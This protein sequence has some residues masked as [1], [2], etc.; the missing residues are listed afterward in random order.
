MWRSLRTQLGLIFLAF[1]M[2]VTGS[3]TATFWLVKTQHDDAT[4]INLAGRQRM[5]TQQMTRLALTQPDSPDLA[6][7]SQRFEQTLYALRNGGKALDANG[8]LVTLPTTTNPAIRS[9]LDEAAH[10]WAAFSQYLG[11]SDDDLLLIESDH[12]LNQLDQ[13][14]SA[15]A[16]EAQAKT[17]R[18]RQIQFAFLISAFLLLG[19]GYF[20]I[21]HRLLR[22]LAMLGKT[23][24][25]IGAGNLS[26][27]VPEIIGEELGQLGQTMEG[28]R[29]EIATAQE[30]LE[31]RVAQRTHELTAAFEFSQE[32]V[33]QL[34][35]TP[36]LHSV[37]RRARDL[38]DGQVASLCVLNEDSRFLELV[39]S[40]GATDKQMGLRH[41]TQRGMALPVIQQGQTVA[42][43]DSCA[44]CGFLHQFPGNPCIAAPLQVGGETLGALCVV[45]PNIGFDAEEGRAL[46]L[47]ANAAA[48]AIDNARLMETS[49]KRAET[50][51]SLAERERLSAELHD[52]LAQT[53]SFLNIKIEQV[54]KLITANR[55]TAVADELTRM[56]TAV[57]TAFTQVRAALTGLQRPPSDSNS[58]A[59]RLSACVAEFRQTD[60]LPVK[61]AI[62]DLSALALPRVTQNQSL[63]IVRE[64]LINARRHAQARRVSVH[65][66]RQNGDAQFIVE[67]DGRGFNPAQVENHNHLGL[68]IMRS[69][70][71]RSGGQLA[72]KSAP[73]GG[74]QIIA[75]FPLNGKA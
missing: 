71:E 60:N 15:F 46:T 6:E 37:A 51:A 49:K 65:V 36:L 19:W 61:L 18:L 31:Q 56:E 23:A 59:Q 8:R 3:V 64:A 75:S 43:E 55:T 24:Q 67:D 30:L 22:P 74:T 25:Q 54:A 27:P 29:V 13:A 41:S 42:V 57:K 38:L 28:M 62:H 47:L 10:V 69:R 16:A 58:F 48:I 33:H 40:S 68:K 53:F 73:G 52:N 34:D 7:A 35:L 5:L 17:I 14:V 39:A 44:N 20:I 66:Q 63:H 12:L 11:S 70:A 4:I 21:R 32:I 9:Q 1:F 50:N 2:L 72:I 45:R 26:H